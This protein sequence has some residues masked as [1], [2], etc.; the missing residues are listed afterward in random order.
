MKEP[1][2]NKVSEK[3]HTKQ[4]YEKIGD[5]EYEDK[6]SWGVYEKRLKTLE[7][8]LVVALFILAAVSIP[9][10]NATILGNVIATSGVGSDSIG[11]VMLL[12]MFL[13]CCLVLFE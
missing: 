5:I 12:L 6:S 10:L 4:G 8:K 7:T 9:F 1:H 3:V 13:G 2:E 11:L